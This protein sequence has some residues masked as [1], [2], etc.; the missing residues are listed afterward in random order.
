MKKSYLFLLLLHVLLVNIAYGQKLIERPDGKRMTR[1]EIDKIVK[2]LSESGEVTGL[3][4]GIINN[5]KPV[6]IKAYG[7][8]NKGQKRMNDTATCFYAASLAKPL[9]AYIVMQLVDRGLIDLDKPISQY[10]PNSL[11][12]YDNYKDLAGDERWKLITPRYCLDH[13][14]GFPNWRQFNPRDNNKLEIFFTPGSRYAYSGEGIYLL[15]MVVE[16]VTGKK[17]E[18]LAEENIFQPFGMRLTS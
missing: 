11:P 9:F 17:L 2:Q 14:T 4:L 1:A 15:Q 13:T 6:Y 3:C 12:E 8:K 10:L 16:T 7:Y 18:Q 5:N